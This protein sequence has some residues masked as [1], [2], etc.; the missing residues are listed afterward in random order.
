MLTGWE[1]EKLHI[2]E[3]QFWKSVCDLVTAF[4]NVILDTTG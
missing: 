1:F 2:I 4:Y 3:K